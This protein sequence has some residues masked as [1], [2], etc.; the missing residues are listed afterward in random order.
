MSEGLNFW[1]GIVFF[2]LI[3]GAL[4]VVGGVFAAAA[5]RMMVRDDYFEEPDSM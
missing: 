1:Y 4:A 3:V 2:V 5:I